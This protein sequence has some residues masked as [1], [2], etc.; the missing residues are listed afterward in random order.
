MCGAREMKE[1]RKEERR[2]RRYSLIIYWFMHESRRCD[3]TGFVAVVAA[4]TGAFL[5]GN[6]TATAAAL[7]NIDET[8]FCCCIESIQRFV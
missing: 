2:N 4:I 8:R 6:S 7:H 1:R 5:H 3:Y